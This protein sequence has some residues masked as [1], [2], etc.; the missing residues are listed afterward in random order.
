MSFVSLGTWGGAKMEELPSSQLFYS[1]WTSLEEKFT[2]LV[3]LRGC[4]GAWV[5]V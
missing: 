5:R 1:Y 2:E 4:V 3:C